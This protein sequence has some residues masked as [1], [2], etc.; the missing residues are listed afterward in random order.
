MRMAGELEDPEWENGRTKRG[1]TG[2]EKLVESVEEQS[3][4]LLASSSCLSS[5]LLHFPPT[6][7]EDGRQVHAHTSET[8]THVHADPSLRDRGPDVT[9]LISLLRVL[10]S[11]ALDTRF[12]SQSFPLTPP[13]PLGQ[14][15][16][17]LRSVVLDEL[18]QPSAKGAPTT[19]PGSQ[20]R[21]PELRSPRV[22]PRKRARARHR[23]QPHCC[24]LDFQRCGRGR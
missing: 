3:E 13:S 2:A 17:A 24:R 4:A 7:L 22:H 9:P 23:E 19:R 15:C 18:N 6:Y 5:H 10:A 11:A 20:R 12:S 14:L 1:E 8:H 21:E 16:S